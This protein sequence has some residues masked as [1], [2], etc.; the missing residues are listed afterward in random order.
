ML[1]FAVLFG[2]FIGYTLLRNLLWGRLVLTAGRIE[3]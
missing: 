1:K 3:Q 2:I